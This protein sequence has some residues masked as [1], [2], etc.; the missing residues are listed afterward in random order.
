MSILEVDGLAHSFADKQLYQNAAFRLNKED[1]MG[2][3]GQNGAGKSTLIKIITGQ[4]LPDEGSIKWQKGVKIGYLDQYAQNAHE[5]TVFAF[6]KSAFANLY[7]ISA[8]QAKCYEEY[9]KT[10]NDELLEKAGRYQEQLE[11]GSFYEI[12]TRIAQVMTGLGIDAIGKERQVDQCSGGQRSKIILAKLLLEEPDVLLLDEP[13]NYLDT[14]HIEWLIGYL[15]DFSGSFMVIS[16][17]YNFLEQ[18]TNTIIDVAFGKITKYT[19]SFSAAVKQKEQKKEVQLKA[20]EKQQ[21]QI[22][23]DEAY[24]RKNKAGSRSTMAKSRQKRLDKLERVDPPSDALQAHFK[25]P[26]IELLSSATL[27]V[28]GLSVGYQAPLLEPVTFSLSHGEKVVLK[29]FNGVGKSTLIKSILGLIPTFGGSA[30]FVD[31][32]EV[33]YFTQDLEWQNPDQTPLGIV[34]D[35]YPR[36]EAKTVRQRLAR[37]GLSPANIMK[38]MRL[39]SGGEQT[40]VKLCILELKPSNFLIMDEPTNHLDE[41]TKNALRDA[42]IAFPGNVLLVSHEEPFYEGWVDRIFD[43]ESVRLNKN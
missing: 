4:E 16:H 38:P 27:V 34:Q 39:L 2:V 24:I 29:G 1:H 8:A 42:L 22:E 40:K 17:D 21:R 9:A 43:V 31:A 32:A 30:K 5:L 28:E 6:L 10:M 11:A 25:F 18:I 35:V 23:K 20:Y 15:R 33:N 19:G 26:Y 12:E 37:A 13:T 41:Q 14:E 36:L 7:R 3:I